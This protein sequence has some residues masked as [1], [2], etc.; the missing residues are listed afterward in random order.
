[1][2]QLRYEPGSYLPLASRFAAQANSLKT[3]KSLADA[4]AIKKYGSTS[5]SSY[6]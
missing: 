1:M 3:S 5:D 2:P 4:D 6:N